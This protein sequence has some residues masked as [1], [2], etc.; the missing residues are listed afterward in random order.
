MENHA[1]R[2]SQSYRK[3]KKTGNKKDAIWA[4]QFDKMAEKTVLKAL[5]SKYGIMSTDMQKAVIS[6]H[7][8]LNINLETG[9][10]SINYIDNPETIET[11]SSAEQKE[12]LE[13]Y[14][15]S[16]ITKLLDKM[17]IESLNKVAKSDLETLKNA[18]EQSE[19]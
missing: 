18:T 12:L 11:I 3:Y 7:A 2:Y 14:G 4:S 17:G 8:K 1:I 6:D 13:K 5:I 9:E 15:A 10:E 16:K 19:I